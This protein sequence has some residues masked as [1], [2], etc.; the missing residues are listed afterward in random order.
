MKYISFICFLLL[1]ISCNTA[2]TSPKN[3]TKITAKNIAIDSTLVA[4]AKIDSMIA[5]YKEKMVS[6]MNRVLTKTA[7]D[8]TK[9][10]I[11]MQSTLGNLIAD[12]SYEM[13][14]PIYQQKTK[15]N[16]DFAMFNSGGLRAPIS[17]GNVTKESAF[18]LMPFE[19]EFVVVEL[20][21]EKIIELVNYLIQN[22]TA[23]PLSK[24]IQ[25]TIINDDFDLLING[26]KFDKNK[27]YRVLTSDYLQTGGDRMNFF[28]NPISLTKLNYKI[29]DAIIAYFEKE[30][31][32][33]AVIDNR[34][35][36]Q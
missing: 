8:I 32:L 27:N 11:G 4:D 5:P 12:L 21:R 7:V 16:I 24:Q 20:S 6:E 28:K 25:L 31:E 14:N 36:V 2:T 29:R 9:K 35:I 13:A 1:A 10:A 15:Q 23:H 22:K 34:I 3:L 18:K 33:K 17:A 19:N 30:V 26:K